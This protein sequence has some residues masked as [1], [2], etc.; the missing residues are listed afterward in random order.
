[1]EPNTKTLDLCHA[2]FLQL[3]NA[4]LILKVCSDWHVAMFLL[5]SGARP[6]LN[7]TSRLTVGGAIEQSPTR[8]NQNN[9]RI[10]PK[11]VSLY[12]TC[13]TAEKVRIKEKLFCVPM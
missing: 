2:F 8:N 1:M 6:L 10:T 4:G 13:S 9:G 7:A 3:L 5:F 11:M 12:I